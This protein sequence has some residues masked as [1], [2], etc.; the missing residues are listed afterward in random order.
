[1]IWDMSRRKTKEVVFL[2]GI[3]L[4]H[5]DSS[6]YSTNHFTT[7]FFYFVSFPRYRMLALRGTVSS[8]APSD[9]L[10]FNI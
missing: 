8:S 4:F 9:Q 10:R 2:L 5:F 6:F 3:E 7:R 1:M